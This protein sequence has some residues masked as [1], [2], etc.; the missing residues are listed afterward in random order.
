MHNENGQVEL[1]KELMFMGVEE[2]QNYEQAANE[3]EWRI[4]M[5]REI[6]FIE[7]NNT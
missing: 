2:P 7:K 6:D 4:E 3:R 5:Q 1:D